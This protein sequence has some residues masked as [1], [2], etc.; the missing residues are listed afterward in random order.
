MGIEVQKED[1]FWRLVGCH[2]DPAECSTVGRAKRDAFGFIDRW[3]LS[4]QG[5]LFA[6]QITSTDNVPARV[7]KIL[8]DSVGHGKW[9]IRMAELARRLLIARVTLIVAGWRLDEATYRYKRT[10]VTLELP[11]IH[12]ALGMS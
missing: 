6:V 10:S 1:V 11:E 7:R 2:V 5:E 12:E 3:Y 4:K 8:Y 9:R